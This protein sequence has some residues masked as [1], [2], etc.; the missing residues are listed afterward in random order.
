[1]RKSLRRGFVLTALAGTCVFAIAPAALAVTN[2][3]TTSPEAIGLYANG[4]LVSVANTPDQTTVGTT[5]VASASVLGVLTAN[6]LNATVVSDNYSYASVASLS[7]IVGTPFTTISSG[8]IESYCV[9]TG[10]G[11]FSS[12]YVTIENLDIDGATFNGTL[13]SPQT[14]SVSLPTGLAS[15]TVTLDQELTG[16]VTGSE[17]FNAID[18]SFTTTLGL[19]EDVDIASATCGPYNSE[20]VTPLASGNGLGIGLGLLG[21]VGAG[22]ATVYVRRRRHGLATA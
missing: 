21:L 19:T 5:T 17:T 8:T 7:T 14:L 1:M 18:I 12:S 15:L 22:V 6:V 10:P 13:T 16:P 11:D 2:G 4:T 20:E 3:P 9:V